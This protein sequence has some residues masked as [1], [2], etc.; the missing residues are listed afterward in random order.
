MMNA[1]NATCDPGMILPLFEQTWAPWS[2]I[3]L[4]A[5][6]LGW[7]FLGIAIISDIFMQAIE[8]I[9]SEKRNV[10]MI[11][12]GKEHQYQVKVWNATVA[13]LTLMAL[14]SSAPE[15][16][17]SLIEILRQGMK[18][19]DL[20]P[21]T[22]VGSAAYNLFIISAVC[23]WAVPSPKVKHIERRPV[24]FV[25]AAA[26]FLAY[27]WLLV[28]L[29]GTSPHMIDVWEGVLTFL[30]FPMLVWGAY[31]V[32]IKWSPAHVLKKIV[33]GKDFGFKPASIPS[34]YACHTL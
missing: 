1:T 33:Q 12:D 15:I 16:M 25:T 11:I 13:N 23:V 20:G 34:N 14:G 19:G 29:L 24:F 17:L 18:A 22:I 3:T 4:Y 26:S 6:G 30:F 5:L 2:R 8:V 21:S 32:D 10:T 9:T 7:C 31:L 27:L 28:I